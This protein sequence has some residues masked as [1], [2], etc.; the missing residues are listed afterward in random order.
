MV[1]MT[2][3]SGCEGLGSRLGLR[4]CALGSS[5]RFRAQGLGSGIGFGG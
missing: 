2:E 5:F 1:V 4:S 3:S